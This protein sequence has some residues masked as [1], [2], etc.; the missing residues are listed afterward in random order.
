[1]CSEMSDGFRL[2]FGGLTIKKHQD[3]K[4]LVVDHEPLLRMICR[5]ITFDSGG[6]FG[7]EG[8]EDK[9]KAYGTILAFLGS[10]RKGIHPTGHQASRGCIRGLQ[11]MSDQPSSSQ[12]YSQHTHQPR[13]PPTS[14]PTNQQTNQPGIKHFYS[15][16]SVL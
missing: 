5:T 8:R 7:V 12:R 11:S 9:R 3:V 10:F 13:H 1:M 14:Q 4:Q 16:F 2:T 15:I 6:K